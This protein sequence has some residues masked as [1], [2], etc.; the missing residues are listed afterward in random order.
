MSMGSGEEIDYSKF[1]GKFIPVRNEEETQRIMAEK[2]KQR[3][4]E[5]AK[6]AQRY[7]ERKETLRHKYSPIRHGLSKEEK[8]EFVEKTQK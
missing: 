1:V 4:E 3:D 8:E 5:D 7:K 6:L 2:K